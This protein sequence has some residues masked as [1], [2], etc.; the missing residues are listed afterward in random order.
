[1]LHALGAEQDLE[2]RSLWAAADE[3]AR[4]RK[5]ARRHRAAAVERTQVLDPAES[6]CI[7]FERSTPPG[8]ARNYARKYGILVLIVL[9]VLIVLSGPLVAMWT[10]SGRPTKDVGGTARHGHDVSIA[11][12]AQVVKEPSAVYTDPNTSART[13]EYKYSGDVVVLFRP[14]NN[15]PHWRAIRTPADSPGYGWMQASSLARC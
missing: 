14:S 10:V 6:A 9:I 2:W 15:P 12:C 8:R 1:M 5:A 11:L 13:I 4:K 3:A 7:T